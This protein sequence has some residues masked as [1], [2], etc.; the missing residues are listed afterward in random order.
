MAQFIINVPNDVAYDDI[1]NAICK[2]S[3][4]VI[5]SHDTDDSMCVNDESST[6]R[7][8]IRRKQKLSNEELYGDAMTLEESKQLLLEHIHHHFHHA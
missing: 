8:S 6:Y 4:H 7:H 3:G 5:G 2:V 1:E